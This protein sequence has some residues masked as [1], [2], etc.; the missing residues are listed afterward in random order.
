LA[1]N[2]LVAGLGGGA[3]HDFDLLA[4]KVYFLNFVH[5]CLMFLGVKKAGAVVAARRWEREI[6]AATV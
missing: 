3:V 4:A 6:Y 5:S 1:G 2:G